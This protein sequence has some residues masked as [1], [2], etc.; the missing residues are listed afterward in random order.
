MSSS[1]CHLFR[2]G[3]SGLASSFSLD[4]IL[5]TAYL[6]IDKIGYGERE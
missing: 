3:I 4:D 6:K 1:H 5:H 2:F